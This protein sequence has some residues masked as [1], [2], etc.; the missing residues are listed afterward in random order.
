MR[1]E[2]ATP[3]G[4][5]RN[6]VREVP[7][8]NGRLEVFGGSGQP[9]IDSLCGFAARENPRRP[10]LFVSKFNGRYSAIRPSAMDAASTVLAN[11]IP[12]DVDGPVLFVGIA[13][14]G[15]AI[16]SSVHSIWSKRSQ[17]NDSLL[18]QTTRHT[19]SARIALSF[20]EPHSHA[21]EHTIHWPATRA[22][23]DL[24]QAARTVVLIDDEIT[25]GNTLSNAAQA[26]KQVVPEL[27][28]VYQVVLTDWSNGEAA[29]RNGKQTGLKTITSALWT[30][31]YRFVPNGQSLLSQDPTIH[32]SARRIVLTD[33]APS[34]GP[35]LPKLP[36]S[37]GAHVLRGSRVLVVG[38]G[39]HQVAPLALARELEAMGVDAW[40]QATTRAPVRI[41]G[42]IG[43][44]IEFS[45]TYGGNFPCF[46]Y[47]VRPSDFD[48][49]LVCT[50]DPRQIVPPIVIDSLGADVIQL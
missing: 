4:P 32:E 17:R 30:G 35:Q 49:V 28:A 18:L 46:L 39:E 41:G 48:R 13:E 7:L 37:M 47:N 44:R 42:V 40:F 15:I 36:D 3:S 27:D 1:S 20:Q 38:T 6:S 10:F 33:R 2:V 23:C 21:R 16:A 9:D 24:F 12:S 22:H 31:S 5:M 45:D 29:F 14:A 25:T 34:V 19:V 8:P 43:D 26:L 50:E 11:R